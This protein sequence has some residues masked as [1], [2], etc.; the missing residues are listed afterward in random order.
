VVGSTELKSRVDDIERRIGEA[1]GDMRRYSEE[2]SIAA[3]LADP[4]FV[5]GEHFGVRINW[6][7]AGSSDAIGITGAAVLADGMFGKTG[8]L[9]GSVG[10]GFAGSTIG[11][12][13]GLQLTW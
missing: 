13:A 4:D 9:T 6:A 3:S 2:A 11:G 5:A 10:V 7:N 8:R 1:F 12:R